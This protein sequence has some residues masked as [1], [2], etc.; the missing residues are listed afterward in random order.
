[1]AAQL[2]LKYQADVASAV[3]C[4]QKMKE[5]R[6]E[7]RIEESFECSRQ[8][9]RKYVDIMPDQLLSF[10]FNHEDGNY[11]LVCDVGNFYVENRTGRGKDAIDIWLGG[12]YLLCHAMSP[13]LEAIRRGVVIINEVEGFDWKKTLEWTLLGNGFSSLVHPTPSKLPN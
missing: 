11:V 6:E 10:A 12:S 9:I 1:M 4:A 5:F 3:E 13:D 8:M 2:A 7:H